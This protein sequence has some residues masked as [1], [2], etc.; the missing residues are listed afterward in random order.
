MPWNTTLLTLQKVEMRMVVVEKR[1]QIHAVTQAVHHKQLI[2][3]RRVC[4]DL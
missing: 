3:N 4:T 2:S 1:G